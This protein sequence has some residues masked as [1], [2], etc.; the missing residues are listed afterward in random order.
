MLPYPRDDIPDGG[1]RGAPV[2]T[3]C[4]RGPSKPA[5]GAFLKDVRFGLRVL[6]R[7]PAFTLTAVL[8][9][10]LGT[11]AATAIFSVLDGVVLRPLPYAN[12]DRLVTLWATNRTH[13]LSHEPIL[14]GELPRL[15][16]AGPRVRRRGCLVATRVHA[17]RAGPGPGTRRRR[18][19]QPQSLLGP[20]RV[21]GARPGVS[22]RRDAARDRRV[23]GGDQPSAL[24]DAVPLGPGARRPGDHAQRPAVHRA[25][26]DAGGLRLSRRR[27]RVAA[28]AVGPVAAQPRREV[29][30]GGGAARAGR[31]ARA[32]GR[33]ARRARRPS[34]RRVRRHERGLEHAARAARRRGGRLLPARVVRA[35][36]GRRPAARSSRA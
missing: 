16:R 27:G 9:L 36:G 7:A 22:A 25:R 23:R 8:T 2:P 3:L 1:P 12:P 11:G 32:G 30:G 26:C 20:R 4:R 18:R 33:R 21:A 13:G 17:D 15:P 5:M 28:P 24:A 19:G 34:R 10:G 31:D 35:D 14:A 29:H 6:R